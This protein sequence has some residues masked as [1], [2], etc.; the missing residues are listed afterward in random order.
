MVLEKFRLVGR[1][2]GRSELGK[3]GEHLRP[4]EREVL[5][6]DLAAYYIVRDV[7]YPPKPKKVKFQKPDGATEENEVYGKGKE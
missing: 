7:F 2:R 4:K 6:K 5:A 3:R 1:G